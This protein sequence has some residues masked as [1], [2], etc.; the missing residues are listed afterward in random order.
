MFGGRI[1]QKILRVLCNIVQSVSYI[2]RRHQS[3]HCIPGAGPR[4]LCALDYA[5]PFEGKMILVLIDAHSKWV[6]AICTPSATSAVVVDELRTLFAQFG[7]PETV[8]TD[9][10]PCFVGTEFEEFKM[11]SSISRQHHTTQLP[12]DLLSVLFSWLRK[13]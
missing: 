13:A 8:V 5:G 3:L 2:S 1:S 12:T 9:N 7:L 11:V 4:D 10:G 6:E